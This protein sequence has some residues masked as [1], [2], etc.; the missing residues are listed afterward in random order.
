MLYAWRS[1]AVIIGNQD[2]GLF[3]GTIEFLIGNSAEAKK[4]LN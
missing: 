1:N 3:F 4:I 2:E